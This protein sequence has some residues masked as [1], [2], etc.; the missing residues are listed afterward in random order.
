MNPF[1]LLD[2]VNESN[3]IEGMGDA[4]ERELDAHVQLLG[5]PRVTIEVLERFV[6]AIRGGPLRREFGMNVRIG[7]HTPTGGGPHIVESLQ[8]LLDAKGTAYER[9]RH[10]EFIHPFMDGNGRSG[11]AL[12]L[13]DMGGMR[14]APLG[15]LHTWY[16]QS[17]DARRS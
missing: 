10:Y 12:W 5:E 13:H 9:H 6:Q 8:S 7:R 14:F 1:S 4:E 15:F 3:R 16:Y 17:L 2:F 11:R